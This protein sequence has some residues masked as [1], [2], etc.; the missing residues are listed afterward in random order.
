LDRKDHLTHRHCS[1]FEEE[2]C[3]PKIFDNG[4]FHPMNKINPRLRS[5]L[6]TPHS[7]M[8]RHHHPSVHAS[9]ANATMTITSNLNLPSF[10]P[11][12]RR[13]MAR[14]NQTWRMANPT[15]QRRRYWRQP[16]AACA[17]RSI[18]APIADTLSPVIRHATTYPPQLTS[19]TA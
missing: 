11:T 16:V 3:V 10:P 6:A 14:S 7:S 15:K 13:G 1:G 17:L 4:S 8:A 2:S 18:R 9:F 5:F 12:Q 19:A